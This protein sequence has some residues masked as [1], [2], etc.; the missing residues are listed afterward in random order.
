[1]FKYFKLE[2]F[3][4]KHCG[5]NLIDE[6]FVRRLDQLRDICGFPFVIVSGY[7]CPTHNAA[8]GGAVNSQHMLGLA[9]DIAA[10]SSQAYMILSGAFSL[11]FRGIGVGMAPGKSQFVHL[12]LREKRPAVWSY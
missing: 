12:D 1:M 7:R 4:C 3:A 6:N 2:E 8:V 11:G 9:A 5:E 10:T